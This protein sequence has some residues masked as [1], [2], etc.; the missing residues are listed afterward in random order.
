M[1]LAVEPLPA[2]PPVAQWV[3]WVVVELGFTPACVWL[4]AC[5]DCDGLPSCFAL[6]GEVDVVSSFGCRT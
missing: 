6:P 4:E 2:V 3:H 5:I 1:H